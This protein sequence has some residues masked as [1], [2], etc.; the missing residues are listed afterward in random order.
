MKVTIEKTQSVKEDIEIPIYFTTLTGWFHM[1]LPDG[2]ILQAS[3]QHIGVY[4]SSSLKHIYDTIK[5]C[6]QDAFIEAYCNAI[7]TISAISGIEHL[8]LSVTYDNTS[9]PE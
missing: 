1:A 7:N 8:P 5:P 6:S 4:G 3:Q 9:N 2:Q